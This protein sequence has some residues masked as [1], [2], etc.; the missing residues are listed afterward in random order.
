MLKNTNNNKT[1]TASLVK[2][3][4]LSSRVQVLMRPLD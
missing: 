4:L 1:T 2:P 3:G